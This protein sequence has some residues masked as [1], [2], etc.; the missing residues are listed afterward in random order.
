M[1]APG[2]I[3]QLRIHNDTTLGFHKLDALHPH[4]TSIANEKVGLRWG[5]EE[6]GRRWGRPRCVQ[7]VRPTE[8][9][10]PFLHGAEARAPKSGCIAPLSGQTIDLSTMASGHAFCIVKHMV[11]DN[12]CPFRVVLLYSHDRNP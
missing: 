2:Q 9:R 12:V 11:L 5:G 6:A 10:A 3:L 1:A 7:N 4:T 8:A